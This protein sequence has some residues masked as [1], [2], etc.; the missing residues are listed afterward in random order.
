MAVVLV[1][2]AIGLAFLGQR[3]R[4]D[5]M[6]ALLAARTGSPLALALGYR[7]ADGTHRVEI[8]LVLEPPGQVPLGRDRVG[9]PGEARG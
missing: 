7:A 6:P 1:I 3:A 8:P 5:M 4:C 2:G 9:V